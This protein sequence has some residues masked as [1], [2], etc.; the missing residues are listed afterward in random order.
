MME[1]YQHPDIPIS[2]LELRHKVFGNIYLDASARAYG[3]E[4]G[5]LGE[6]YLL[7]ALSLDPDLNASVSPKWITA[8]IGYAL[9]NLVLDPASYIKYVSSHLPR[10]PEFKTWSR[11]RLTAHLLAAQAFEML[12]RGEKPSARSHAVQAIISDFRLIKN[13]GL[14]KIPLLCW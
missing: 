2:V 9:G 10:T 7:Q 5:E 1:L 8:L 12:V 6:I 11:R 14:V 13:R 3:A 4:M